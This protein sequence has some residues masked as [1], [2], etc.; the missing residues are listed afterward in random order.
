MNGVSIKY[1]FNDYGRPIKSLRIKLNAVCNFD[2]IFCHM[3]GTERS[4]SYM[5]PED[6]KNI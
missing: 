2:C 6:I 1:V 5:S 3:E 4:I